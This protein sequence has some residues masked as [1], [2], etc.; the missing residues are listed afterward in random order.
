[1]VT[2]SGMFVEAFLFLLG[3]RIDDAG[4]MSL[5]QGVESLHAAT[6]VKPL[7]LSGGS[8]LLGGGHH[9]PCLSHCGIEPVKKGAVVV[10]CIAANAALGRGDKTGLVLVPVLHQ[11][12]K[13]LRRFLL[14]G[15]Q[16][17]EKARG[18]VQ[19]QLREVEQGLEGKLPLHNSN[20]A[21]EQCKFYAR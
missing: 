17:A 8:A 10:P 3:L 5:R 19:A 15:N 6:L 7:L 18:F 20:R 16:L 13:P 21:T 12:F 2:T 1:M 11:E 9:F 14:A 4:M